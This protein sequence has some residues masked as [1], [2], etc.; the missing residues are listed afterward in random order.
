[1]LASVSTLLVMVAAIVLPVVLFGREADTGPLQ[2]AMTVGLSIAIVI[3][4]R[5]TRDQ[6]RQLLGQAMVEGIT[7]A[8]ATFFVIIAI[9]MLISSLLLSGTIATLLSYGAELA[10]PTILYTVALVL[11]TLI[12]VILGSSFTT[13]AGLGVPFVALAPLMGLSPEV[14]AAA[15]VAGAFTGDGIAKV[16]D[17]LVLTIDMVGG[18]TPGSQSRHMARLLAPGWI[19]TLG[20][21]IFLGIRHGEGSFDGSAVTKV[22]QSEFSISLI[23]LVPLVVVFVLSSRSTA[24]FAVLA[25]ALSAV[26]LAGFTQPGL[27]ERLAGNDHAYIVQWLE[28]SIE[29]LANGFHLDS[30]TEELNAIFFG[31]GAVGMLPTLWLILVASAYGGLMSKTGML[32]TAIAPLMRW[33]QT[34]GRLIVASAATALSFNLAMADPYV[35][36]IVSSETFR[37]RFKQ[38]RLEPVV[39]SVSIAGSGSLLSA[40]IPWN[41]H[42]AFV[43][44]VLGI[45]TF[46]FAGY[47]VVIWMTP[48]VL[49]GA[50]MSFYR[51]DV[52]QAEQNP[53]DVYGEVPAQ[54][55]LR[56]TSI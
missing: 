38:G 46:S 5:A 18:V 15:V 31:G 32:A 39:Q 26:V 52:I 41:V 40:I 44:G 4:A 9:G 22:I 37:E 14:T 33:A 45:A 3:A 30:T 50:A 13:I 35:S 27:V 20:L 21:M 42:G 25:G 19:A 36:I 43:A 49:V 54:P 28:V 29:T 34:A 10:S 1:M 11:A 16:S 12:G 53:D 2:V 6:A 24:F 56:R 51:G 17:T 7:S 55:P 23:A 8:I 48:L 47:A